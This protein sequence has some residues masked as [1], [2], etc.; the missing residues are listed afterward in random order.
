MRILAYAM[1]ISGFV[2]I[3]FGQ[4]AISQII[5]R[6]V[7]VAYYDKIPKQQS[8]SLE[9]V[10]KGVRDVVFDFAQHSEVP[11]SVPQVNGAVVQ[12]EFT[13]LLREIC[14]PGTVPHAGPGAA[15]C[16]CWLSLLST[17]R[18]G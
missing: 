5:P 4:I 1:L 12:G 6:A 8:Y 15:G 9:D 17:C 13:S 18:W 11:C 14:A 2:W 7:T 16:W 3:C 10:Q